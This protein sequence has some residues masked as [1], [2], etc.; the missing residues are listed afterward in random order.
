MLRIDVFLGQD[1]LDRAAQA[2]DVFG[3]VV[4]TLVAAERHE[5]AAQLGFLHRWACSGEVERADDE[6]ERVGRRSV[7]P[8][9]A[10]LLDH[11]CARLADER[12][13]AV[14]SVWSVSSSSASLR[15]IVD[16]AREPVEAVVQPCFL[17]RV[18]AQLEQRLRQ[19]LRLRR[20]AREE[21]AGA[22]AR[23]L[24]LVPR[25]AQRRHERAKV[26]ADSLE[27]GHDRV[28]RDVDFDWKWSR[29]ERER[30][31]QSQSRER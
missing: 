17:A 3:H 8:A 4:D 26:L 11:A 6:L 20:D 30:H 28:L 27:I 2:H 31:Q 14:Y 19:L 25:R 7:E 10:H 16:R 1:R 18:A 12:H 22:F 24:H 15:S 29:L 21:G 23:R 5:Q 9:I 13:A